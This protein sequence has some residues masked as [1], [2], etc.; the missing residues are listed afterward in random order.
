MTPLGQSEPKLFRRVKPKCTMRELVLP[1]G[2]T[3]PVKE[4]LEDQAYADALRYEGLDVRKRVILHGPPGCGKTSIAHALAAELGIGL[5]E[6]SIAETC[7]SYM[8]ESEKQVEKIFDFAAQNRCVLLLDEFDSIGQH[9]RASHG[10]ANQTENRIVNT[11]LTRLES[12]DPLGLI[13]ACTNYLDFIDRAILRR[14]DL[15]LEIPEASAAALETLARQILRD[16]H[17]IQLDDVL[18]Y[19]KT[20]AEVT[21]RANDLL[22]RAV[23][24]AERER[25][26]EMPLPPGGE[27]RAILGRLNGDQ[28]ELKLGGHT[29]YTGFGPDGV[30]HLKGEL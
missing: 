17:G 29:L 28:V 5:Y 21:K 16:R 3:G 1:E 22:R 7:S 30:A 27:A 6:V 25:R 24:T 23:I 8:G 12:V 19:A 14:F 20:P 11:I 10:N 18:R 26:K 4:L 13:V 9:R 15:E 2:V